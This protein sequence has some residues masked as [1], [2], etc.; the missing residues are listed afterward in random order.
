MTAIASEEKQESL[1]ERVRS[2]FAR[3][4]ST[5]PTV[6]VRAPG[7]VNLIGEHTDYNDGFVLPMAIDRWTCIALRPRPGRCV[8]LHSLNLRETQTF[9]LD[10]LSPGAVKGWIAYAHGVAGALAEA[11]FKLDGWEGVLASNVPIG[12]GLSSSASVE[13]AVAR[14]FASVSGFDWDGPRV[15]KLCQ[16]A[17][18]RWAG[19]NCGIMDQ[20]ISACGVAG[21]AVL[22]DCR[23]LALR[24]VPLP[25]GT[26]VVVLDTGKRRGLVDSTYNERRAQC[27]AAAKTCEANALRDV[28]LA[29]LEAKAELLE[30][31]ARRRAR[32]V[33][34]ENARTLAAADAMARDDARQLGALMDQS[35][36]SLRDDFEVSCR[37]LDVMVECARAQVGC[38]GARLTGA[39]F[40]G[41][42]IA[43]VETAHVENFVA[44]V[45]PAY[46]RA[47]GMTPAVYVCQP[48]AGAAEIEMI[49]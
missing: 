15:A 38:V 3:R 27:A 11:G 9:S 14:A 13:L 48:S 18:N 4:F 33:I 36:A 34:S 41:C 45:A 31:L 22:M 40:G 35:H 6:M 10:Q 21:H 44:R 19:V 49:S 17:E 46:E 12:A 8:Q 2:E 29:K 28:T 37:E 24:P 39:G 30:P 1:V 47:A 42:A 20:L 7:R 26:C 23:D 43:L 16:R 25:P 32:H 5:A